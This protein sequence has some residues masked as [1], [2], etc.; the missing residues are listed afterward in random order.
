MKTFLKT[1]FTNTAASNTADSPDPTINFIE[2]AKTGSEVPEAPLDLDLSPE[3]GFADRAAGPSNPPPN[4]LTPQTA[5]VALLDPESI[6]V[7]NM[8]N[9]TNDAF[10]TESFDEL[11][12]S[13]T[14]V[15][16]NV[17]P[18]VVLALQPGVA[19]YTTGQPYE[20]VSGERRLRACAQ[21]GVPVRAILVEQSFSRSV[22][23]DSLL[24]NLNR[25]DLSPYEFG[26][27]VH[28]IIETLSGISLGRLASMI[29]R[30]KSVLSRAHDLARLPP[31]IIAAFESSR[32]IRYA[33]AKPLS[34]AFKAAGDVVLEE[35][36]RITAEGVK[37][38]SSEI[39]KRLSDSAS[40]A[41]GG[42]VAPCNTPAPMP[43]KCNDQPVGELSVDKRGEAQ[44]HLNVALTASQ[45]VALASQIETFIRRRV[46]RLPA[47]PR[48][49]ADKA[50]PKSERPETTKAVV[51]S[52]A[53]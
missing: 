14:M 40:Q 36:R 28:H 53:A 52:V 30:D 43:L 22:S 29:G 10:S 48:S 23:I 6:Q 38:K 25:E 2:I 11:C 18:I 49:P 3:A 17:Q 15:G 32:D 35:A 1:D 47:M 42:G 50:Q 46:L 39:V 7:G 13:I 45:R 51:V 9:R 16:G 44:I 12:H 26:R 20:L 34:D 5:M 19:N 8:P 37:L 41:L 31:E 33:D 24:E 21:A 4:V 27:Q